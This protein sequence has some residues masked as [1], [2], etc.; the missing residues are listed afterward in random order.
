M[1][2]V[3]PQ[4][5]HNLASRSRLYRT[6]RQGYEPSTVPPRI[7]RRDHGSWTRETEPQPETR[8][9]DRAP[10]RSRR[11]RPRHGAPRSQRKMTAATAFVAN[12]QP[13]ALRKQRGVLAPFGLRITRAMQPS[14]ARGKTAECVAKHSSGVAP[15]GDALVAEGLVRIVGRQRPKAIVPV[16]APA[17]GRLRQ[18]RLRGRLATPPM[19]ELCTLGRSRSRPTSLPLAKGR[20]AGG[21]RLPA[22]APCCEHKERRTPGATRAMQSRES[23]SA[24]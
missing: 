19:H 8:R 14:A 3:T 2:T 9:H 24:R 11:L 17:P 13:D 21:V 15:A 10:A 6:R 4:S 5:A 22:C 1:S 7:R 23:R 12:Q 16:G 18:P 20:A